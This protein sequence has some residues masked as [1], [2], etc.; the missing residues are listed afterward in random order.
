[1]DK[2]DDNRLD[3]D[4]PWHPPDTDWEW[5]DIAPNPEPVIFDTAA[6]S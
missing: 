4:F 1:M 3:G 5:L 2:E 6:P